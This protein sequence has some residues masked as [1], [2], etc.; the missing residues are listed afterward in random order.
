MT[1]NWR[2]NLPAS[3]SRMQNACTNATSDPAPAAPCC[4]RSSTRHVPRW[5]LPASNFS[6]RRSRSTTARLVA[7]FSGHVD[8]TEVDPGDRINPDTI[9]TN[10]DDRSALLVSFNVP[11]LLVGE[12]QAN[13]EVTLATWNNRGPCF[14][15]THRRG[16]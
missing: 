13:D 6:A 14:Y 4:Q 15:R 10:L 11:E 12:L 7:P 1:R 2:R 8:L 16:R 3:D 9:I 5:N